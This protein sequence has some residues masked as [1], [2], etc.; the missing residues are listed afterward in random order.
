[1]SIPTPPMTPTPRCE[2]LDRNRLDSNDLLAW[3]T[4]AYQLEALITSMRPVDGHCL[5]Q[6]PQQTP[7]QPSP[8]AMAGYCTGYGS[9]PVSESKEYHRVQVVGS[10]QTIGI[11][12][13]LSEHLYGMTQEVGGKCAKCQTFRDIVDSAWPAD[14]RIAPEKP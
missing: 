2:A 1:M 13:N 3:R 5:L 4:L 14:R 10:E 8:C 11:D 6:V 12:R 9:S 7:E